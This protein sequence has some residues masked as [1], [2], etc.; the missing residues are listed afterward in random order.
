[1]SDAFQQSWDLLLKAILPD[2]DFE[3]ESFRYPGR[4]PFS[5]DSFTQTIE[6]E[7]EIARKLI[8]DNVDETWITPNEKIRYA[9]QMSNWDRYLNQYP[10]LL[11][12]F[13]N[14]FSAM[15][16]RHQAS[17]TMPWDSFRNYILDEYENDESKMQQHIREA[18]KRG[19]NIT[20]GGID[21]NP[22]VKEVD[23]M[24][25][26]PG[27]TGVGVANH[28]ASSVLQDYGR[29]TDTTFSPEGRAF[30][31][32]L[33]NKLTAG[34][35]APKVIPFL[36][37]AGGS[38]FP[39]SNPLH[40]SGMIERTKGD[41]RFTQP[42]GMDEDIGVDSMR[43]RDGYWA[44]MDHFMPPD[45]FPFEYSNPIKFKHNVKKVG[46]EIPS[47]LNPD[48]YRRNPLEI[49]YTGDLNTNYITNLGREE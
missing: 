10:T 22:Y 6:V 1:M 21:Y 38:R 31:L 4:N 35:D 19:A 40:S 34:G 13:G 3:H 43:I 8:E 36:S 17:Y 2:L 15:T 27:F 29:L 42:Y 39:P 47:W 44:G 5:S 32:N 12:D 33:G 37:D 23:R 16:G 28:L 11:N 20:I 48:A 41:L 18:E 30:M 25:T 26:M 24:M 9:N 49:L 7:P 14:V 45:P 46:E